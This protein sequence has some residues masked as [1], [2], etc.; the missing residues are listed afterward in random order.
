MG[1]RTVVHAATCLDDISLISHSFWACSLKLTVN[2]HEDETKAK[3]TIF[4][5]NSKYMA[6]LYWIVK[7]WKATDSWAEAS[8]YLSSTSWAITLLHAGAVKSDVHNWSPSW[9][10]LGQL[11]PHPVL[12]EGIFILETLPFNT[13]AHTEIYPNW[14]VWHIH[15][16]QLSTSHHHSYFPSVRKFCLL[17]VYNFCSR[18]LWVYQCPL[19]FSHCT[20]YLLSKQ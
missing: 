12:T 16:P 8:L 17:C 3:R 1:K 19:R 9:S 20:S 6:Q 15:R 10:V 18:C 13:T 7:R 5:P 11:Y 14:T 4:Q 2:S